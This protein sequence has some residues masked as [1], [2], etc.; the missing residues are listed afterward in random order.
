MSDGRYEGEL[1]TRF[2]GDREAGKRYVPEA[3]KVLGGVLADAAHNNLGVHKIRKQLTDGAVIVA[4]KIGDAPP[5]LRCRNRP[6]RRFPQHRQHQRLE[7]GNRHP[8]S[9]SRVSAARL[10]PLLVEVEQPLQDFLFG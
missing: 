3:R 10:R 2:D 1:F 5:Q 4:E 9:L 8:S 6:L 7:I